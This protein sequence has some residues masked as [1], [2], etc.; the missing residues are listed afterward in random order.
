M[1]ID[2][3][4]VPSTPGVYKFFNKHEI[5]YIGKSKKSKKE[6]PLIS[7]NHLKIEKHLK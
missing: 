1:P 4:E 5:I 7:V 3:N 2:L 6:S